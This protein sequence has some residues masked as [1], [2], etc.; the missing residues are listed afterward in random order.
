MSCTF[1]EP[2]E[3]SPVFLFCFPFERPVA[4]TRHLVNGFYPHAE[5]CL[6]ENPVFSEKVMELLGEV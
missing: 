4:H 1:E 6:V 5:N 3:S 2:Q